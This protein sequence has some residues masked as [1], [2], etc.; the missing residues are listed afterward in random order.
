MTGKDSSDSSGNDALPASLPITCPEDGCEHL[1]DEAVFAAFRNGHWP[2]LCGATITSTSLA[3]S[4]GR[5]CPS[6]YE[7]Q[8][9]H[10]APEAA[11][12]AALPAGLLAPLRRV[13]RAVGRR[14]DSLPAVASDG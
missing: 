7:R 14:P 8:Q 3:A 6:C 12:S 4:P 9:Q 11:T 10:P 1:V 5:P 13:L 2:A